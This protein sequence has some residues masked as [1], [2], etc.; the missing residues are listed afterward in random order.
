MSPTATRQT[1]AQLK[2][3]Q[4]LDGAMQLFLKDG[5]EG[6]SMDRVAAAAGVSKNTIYNHF[7]DKEGL[8]VA[9]I[10]QIAQ[11]RFQIVFGS[12]SPSGDPALV[13]RQ[14]ATTLLD[15]I[16]SDREYIDFLRLIIGESGKFPQLSQLFVR[17]LPQKVLT[18]LSHYF[19]THPQL[20]LDNPEAT[21][22]IF[23]GSLMGYIITQEVLHGA[24][25][26]PMSKK[27]LI[28]TLVGLITVN[29]SAIDSRG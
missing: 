24:E 2:R 20:H 26:L 4:I 25:L 7:Q 15:M 8:F 3:Q 14:I 6:T 22:R 27:D 29:A 21:A 23:M 12:L 9:L 10:E 11:N 19:A 13:L 17:S 18:T 1:T 5:Y 28:D 16:M